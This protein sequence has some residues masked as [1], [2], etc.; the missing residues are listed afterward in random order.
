M[1][2]GIVRDFQKHQPLCVRGVFVCVYMDVDLQLGRR[3]NYKC[4]WNPTALMLSIIA[5]SSKL[6]ESAWNHVFSFFFMEAHC[7]STGTVTAIFQEAPLEITDL[8]AY[9][10]VC[11]CVQAF[12]LTVHDVGG[13]VAQWLVLSQ[14]FACSSQIP[15]TSTSGGLQTECLMTQSVSERYWALWCTDNLNFTHTL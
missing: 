4:I 15:Q 14:E 1:H 2:H 6:Q 9:V 13:M 10:C 11:L 7:D 3:N 5:F 12:H 8:C